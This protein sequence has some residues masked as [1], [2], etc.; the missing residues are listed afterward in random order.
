MITAIEAARATGGAWLGPPPAP[1]LV[2]RGGAGD[3]RALAGAEVFFALRGERGD[4]HDHLHRLAGS[5][6]KLAVVGPRAES[7]QGL[8]PGYRGAMLRVGDPLQALGAM[9]AHL[10]RKH[11]P[12]VVAVAGSYGK[13]TAKEVI[14]HVLAGRRRVLKTPG[15]HNNEI[16][17]PL[18]LLGLDGS[19]DTAVLEFSA[20]KEGDIA[21]LGSIAP[22]DIAVLLA[23]GRAHIGVFGSQEAIYRAKG[24]IFAHL[25]PGGLA[26]VGAADRRLR[27]LAGRR[28]TVTFGG[29]DG[30]FRAAEISSDA[31][32]RRRFAGLN[33]TA[34]VAFRAGIGGAH[35]HIPI[36]AAWAVAR[37]LGISD[38]EVAERAGYAPQQKGRAVRLEAPGGAVVI[39]DTYNA[40]PETVIGLIDSLAEMAADERIL[41]LGHL[42]ELEEG[43]AESAALIG[44]RLRPP[45]AKCLVH[46]P[47]APG[48][49]ERLRALAEGVEVVCIEGRDDLI[50]ALREL[51]R[52]GR[53][54][55]IKGA[56]SAHME[57]A[58]HAMLGSKIA[59]DLKS[60]GLISHCT[61]C[62]EMTGQ[63]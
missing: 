11:R 10:V 5:G 8:A 29:P 39:D 45:L 3:T 62:N 19:Q 1:D 46:A 49:C 61:D 21:T 35:G 59:C 42:S 43:L 22:P 2:L 31:M 28:R 54:I 50:A 18:A 40:S 56:R 9:A 57:R 48:F 53:L 4:G 27:Q 26:I 51:D 38:G 16:G 23:V 52:P 36:L 63:G 12:T 41:V 15:S 32:G 25:R 20:R 55:G 6:V 44:A 37:E 58:L 13:T 34:R 7:P 14:A 60:C 30:D 17:V 47:L 33:G 24:E